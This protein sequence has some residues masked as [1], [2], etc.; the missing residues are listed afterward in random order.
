MNGSEFEMLKSIIEQVS[1]IRIII[2]DLEMKIDNGNLKDIKSD[3]KE[4]YKLCDRLTD[5]EKEI[6]YNY[7]TNQLEKTENSVKRFDYE[8]LE[9]IYNLY[10]EDVKLLTPKLMEYFFETV[11][12]MIIEKE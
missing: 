3:F 5:L 1:D 4:L 9:M 2:S 7:L 8:D 6:Y 10:K 11:N 12:K